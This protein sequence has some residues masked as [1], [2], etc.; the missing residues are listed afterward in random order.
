MIHVSTFF[1]CPVHGRMFVG[2]IGGTAVSGCQGRRTLLTQQNSMAH[3]KASSHNIPQIFEQKIAIVHPTCTA[4]GEKEAKFRSGS[5][6]SLQAGQPNGLLLP[7]RDLGLP[8]FGHG[9]Q[10]C[11]LAML[12]QC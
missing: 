3:A 4:F 6:V 7:L 2:G 8:L 1:A 5:N 12:G 10:R 11:S 9:S